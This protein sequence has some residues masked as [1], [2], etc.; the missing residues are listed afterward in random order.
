MNARVELALEHVTGPFEFVVARIGA[1]NESAGI[2]WAESTAVQH[3]EVALEVV[4]ASCYR[5]QSTHLLGGQTCTR[6][7]GAADGGS[8]WAV[9]V[10]SAKVYIDTLDDFRINLLV[11]VDG[12]IAG[13]IERDA[14]KGQRYARTV[15]AAQAQVAAGAA[16]GIVVGE[17]EAGH[18]VE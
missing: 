6:V 10:S 8:R 18:L 3:A 9:D 13:V 16:V 11:G 5:Y 15:E 12:V 7:D 4:L 2:P 17:V 14:V 1:G